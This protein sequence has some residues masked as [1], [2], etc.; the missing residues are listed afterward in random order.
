MNYQHTVPLYPHEQFPIGI[1]KALAF[2]QNAVQSPPALVATM[3]IGVMSEAV[4]GVA[5]VQL[6]NGPRCPTSTWVLG[7]VDSGGGKTPTL[8][9]LRRGVLEW[10]AQRYQ[11]HVVKL[12][13]YEIDH[14]AWK[15]ELEELSCDLRT[16]V[17]KKQ[18]TREARQCLDAHMR[19]KPKKPRRL[20]VTYSDATVEALLHGMAEFWPNVALAIDEASIFFN[21]RMQDGLAQL[22]QTWDGQSISIDRRGQDEPTLIERPRATLILGI[23]SAQLQ[24]Y[25]RRR[26]TEGRDL[27]SMARM[28][29]CSP[30]DYQGFRNV[31]PMELDQQPLDAFHQRVQEL[32]TQS[33]GEDGEPIVQ[34]RLVEFST[35]AA[36]R[37]HNLREQ[38]EWNIRPFGCMANVRDYAAKATRHVAKLAAI[39]EVFENDSDV[40]GLEMLERAINIIEWHI[41]EYQRLFALPAEVPQCEQDA[42][43]L[44]PWLWQFFIRRGNRYLMRNDI[45]KHAPNSIRSKERLEQALQVLCQR[46]LVGLWHL[47]RINIVDMQ[48]GLGYDSAALSVAIAC[49]RH[50]RGTEQK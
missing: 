12:E 21:G 31:A 46:G 39:F 35:E 2:V 3:A 26:G 23:Q 22:N 30:P 5:D 14:Q 37:F 4:Q 40:I 34:K 19:A 41:K 15:L 42:D 49:Y 9:M 25:F 48:P 11:E 6:P 44:Y 8:N 50:R 13:Q 10:E 32:L 43:A 47:G 38:I 36:E 28:L 18:D 45:R 33:I 27:G 24:K 29:V 17:R 1:W 20:K 16:A 7:V